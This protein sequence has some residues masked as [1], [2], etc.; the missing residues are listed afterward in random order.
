MGNP[1][2]N[3]LPAAIDAWLQDFAQS[4]GEI[5]YNDIIKFGEAWPGMMPEKKAA[6]QSLIGKITNAC[7]ELGISPGEAM[8]ADGNIKDMCLALAEI[9][10]P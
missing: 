2:S 6:A 9:V 1:V 4:T 5:D 10:K 3:N 7:G 8:D